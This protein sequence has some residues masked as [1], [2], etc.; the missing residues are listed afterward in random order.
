ME[1]QDGAKDVLSTLGNASLSNNTGSQEHSCS[2]GI[3]VFTEREEPDAWQT[4]RV[5]MITIG[6]FWLVDM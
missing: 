6:E 3:S 5:M 2:E 1:N 4:S